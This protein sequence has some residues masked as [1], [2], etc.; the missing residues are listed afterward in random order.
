V[1]DRGEAGEVAVERDQLAAVLDRDRSDDRV[2]DKIADGVGFVTEA[3][4][5]G[6]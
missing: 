6:R 3:V 4:Q 2:G 5:E 1:A